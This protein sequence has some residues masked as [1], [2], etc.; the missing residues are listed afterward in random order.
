MYLV[1]ERDARRA[2]EREE[3]RLS[4]RARL[5]QALEA[6]CPGRAVFVFGSITRA[7]KFYKQSD[8]DLALEQLPGGVSHYGLM[9]LLEER[10]GRPIDLLLLGET[11]LREKIL[12]E[13]ERWTVWV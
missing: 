9:G 11:R 10:M 1:Q 8:I 3:A 5:H 6:L 4:T 7:G 13:A 12:A 2:R